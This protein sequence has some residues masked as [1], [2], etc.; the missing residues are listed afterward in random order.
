MPASDM[1]ARATS[2]H[3]NAGVGVQGADEYVGSDVQ[4]GV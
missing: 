2:L 3:A 4:V 1:V